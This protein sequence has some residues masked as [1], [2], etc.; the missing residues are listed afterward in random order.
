[1]RLTK[2]SCTFTYSDSSQEPLGH[3][4]HYDADEEDDGLEPGVAQ[5]ERQNEEGHAQED[6]HAGDEL[7][8]V[9]NLD[10]DGRLADL[11]LRRQGGDATHH[12]LVTGGYDDTAGRA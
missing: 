8:E 2:R 3:V 7:D 1:M 12:C 4:G 9:L 11:Q 5:D 10:A 6:G